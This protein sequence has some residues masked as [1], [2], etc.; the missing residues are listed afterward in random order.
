MGRQS[1]EGTKDVK[2]GTVIK[3]NRNRQEQ[4]TTGTGGVLRDMATPK[5]RE[6]DLPS[7]VEAEV[8]VEEIG[9]DRQTEREK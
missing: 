1:D 6:W 4:G 8:R 9:V 5:G 7:A 2:A 3:H